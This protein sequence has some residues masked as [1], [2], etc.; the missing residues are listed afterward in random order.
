MHDLTLLR[1]LFCVKSMYL[2]MAHLIFSG[3]SKCNISLWFICGQ[4]WKMALFCSLFKLNVQ[5]SIFCIGNLKPDIWYSYLV[6]LI[7]SF[8]NMQQIRL[9]THCKTWTCW[10]CWNF[11]MSLFHVTSMTPFSMGCYVACV[12]RI[13]LAP[14]AKRGHMCWLTLQCYR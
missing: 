13:L 1:W 11:K 10:F 7:K 9:F 2:F 6:A 3:T 8:Q 4:S 14:S 12:Y 5:S